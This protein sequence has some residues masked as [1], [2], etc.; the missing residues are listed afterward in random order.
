MNYPCR[1]IFWKRL[2]IFMKALQWCWDHYGLF[3][4]GRGVFFLLAQSDLNH[5]PTISPA[6]QAI[7]SSPPSPHQNSV[8]KSLYLG[9]LTAEK[10]PTFFSPRPRD[11]F[12]S[13]PEALRHETTSLPLLPLPFLSPL[14]PSMDIFILRMLD[15]W[16]TAWW[17]WY[18]HCS[19][20]VEMDFE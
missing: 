2:C 15:V 7:I 13:S 12:L 17:K 14:Y 11:H 9:S 6:S 5:P 3:H 18:F 16:A 1:L 4:P 19:P 20:V 8:S 10:G